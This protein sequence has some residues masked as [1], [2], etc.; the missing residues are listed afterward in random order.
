MLMI[1]VDTACDDDMAVVRV[2]F[3]EHF[4]SNTNFYHIGLIYSSVLSYFS[5]CMSVS[6]SL[7]LSFFFFFNLSI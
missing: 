1:N 2:G 3:S 7:S 4:A 6:L 5:V